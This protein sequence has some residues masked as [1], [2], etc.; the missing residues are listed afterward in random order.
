MSEIMHLDSIRTKIVLATTAALSQ[1][2]APGESVLFRPLHI[3]PLK[4]IIFAE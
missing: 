4:T 3:F 2:R 1:E